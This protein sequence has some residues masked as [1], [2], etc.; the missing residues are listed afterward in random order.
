MPQEICN[1]WESNRQGRY[2]RVQ[3]VDCQYKGVLIGGLVGL[4]AGEEAI[5]GRWQRRLAEL[6]VAET[7]EGLV[8]YLGLKQR[9]EVV[10]SNCLVKEFCWVTRLR[11]G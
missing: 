4:V 1:R 2:R 10:E 9:L 7:D 6:G 5:L 8:K 3:G 11:A